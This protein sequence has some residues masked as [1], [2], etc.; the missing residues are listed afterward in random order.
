MFTIHAMVN[1]RTNQI[2]M[3][4]LDAY[5]EAPTVSNGQIYASLL[6]EPAADVISSY[7]LTLP[8]QGEPQ[9]SSIHV[10]LHF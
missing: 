1:K 4:R 10:A 7:R 9:F 2:N 6:A 8:V 3:P 5:I